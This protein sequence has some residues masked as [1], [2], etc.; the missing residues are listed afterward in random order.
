MSALLLKP[1]Q[2]QE[3]LQNREPTNQQQKLLVSDFVFLLT[4]WQFG[5][6]L[7]RKLV[8]TQRNCDGTGISLSTTMLSVQMLSNSL[9][10]LSHN[11]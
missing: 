1:Y 4:A 6:V 9:S 7:C 2:M 3:Y 10:L 8:L 11:W 5:T